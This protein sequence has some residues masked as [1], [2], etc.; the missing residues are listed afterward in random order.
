[1]KWLLGTYTSCFNRWYK[2]FGHLCSGRYYGEIVHEA[3]EAQ[4]QR[5][6]KEGLTRMKWKEKD[7]QER[8]KGDAFINVPVIRRPGSS[9]RPVGMIILSSVF[10]SQRADE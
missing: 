8:R 7:L 9:Q 3:A 2:E 4:A 6:V 5:L 10:L 1:M